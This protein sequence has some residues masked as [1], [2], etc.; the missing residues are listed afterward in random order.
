MPDPFSQNSELGNQLKESSQRY[1]EGRPLLVPT[2]EKTPHKLGESLG[3][4]N[5]GPPK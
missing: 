4:A 1:L 3:E 2:F 5:S